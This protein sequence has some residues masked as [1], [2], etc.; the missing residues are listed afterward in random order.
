MKKEVL[1]FIFDGYADWE[2][3]LPMAR[4]HWSLLKKSYCC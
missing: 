2:S 1:V 3:V 4:L